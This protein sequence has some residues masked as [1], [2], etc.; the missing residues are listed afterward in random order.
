MNQEDKKSKEEETK[1]KI[2]GKGAAEN[3]IRSN[4]W[5]KELESKRIKPIGRCNRSC[6]DHD[7]EMEIEI[8]SKEHHIWDFLF[9]IKY[10]V[11]IIFE[12]IYGTEIT[13]TLMRTLRE[14]VKVFSD[15]VDAWVDLMNYEELERTDGSLTRIYFRTIVIT[16]FIIGI[17]VL[18]QL[19]DTSCLKK[20]ILDSW[21]LTES[22]CDD[23]ECM[24]TFSVRMRDAGA[25]EFI[26][27]KMV[28]FPI[29]E[30]DQYYL[31]VFDLKNGA[32]AVIDHRPDRT[33]LVGIRDHQDYY[34][35][36]TPYKVKHMMDAY[37]ERSEHPAKD[38][39]AAAKIERCNIKWATPA[40]PMDSAV[41]LMQHM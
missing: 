3:D 36:D 28:F 12:S 16:F 30:N 4:A 29:L 10:S 7:D 11:D 40:H 38:E 32:I 23:D 31:I 19:I 2:N 24:K 18:H 15:V 13:K 35:K 27:L 39:I 21:L 6:D 25:Y 17:R 34:I 41:F 20:K 9:D 5:V 8:T 22:A 14:E 33:P 26:G 37:L 1:N